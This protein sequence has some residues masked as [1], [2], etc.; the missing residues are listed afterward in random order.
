MHAATVDVATATASIAV[1][2]PALLFTAAF[3]IS[4][5]ACDVQMFFAVYSK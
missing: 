4:R 2:S 5:F 1:R 3:H